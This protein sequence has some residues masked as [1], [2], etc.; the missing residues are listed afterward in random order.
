MSTPTI[1]IVS[2]HETAG[3]A[4]VA[5]RRIEAS[6]R[7]GMPDWRIARIAFFGDEN[8]HVGHRHILQPCESPLAMQ[9]MRLPRKLMPSRF[10]R[11]ASRAFAERSLKQALSEI[12]PDVIQL[13]N[14]HGAADW[15]WGPWMVETC[16]QFA[17]VVWTLHD[18]WSF[19]GRCAYAYDCERFV[20]GCDATCPTANEYPRLALE[21]IGPAWRERRTLY[22]RH[23]QR[24]TIVTPSRWLASQARRGLFA[25]HRID[26]IPYG[27]PAADQ[28]PR[29]EAR[30]ALGLAA[31]GPVL[32]LAAVDLRE[33]RKGAHILREL[34]SNKPHCPLT[35]LTMGSGVVPVADSPIRVHSLGYVADDRTKTLAYA[36]A[37][38]LLHPAPVENLPNTVLE[39]MASGTPTIALPIGGLPELVRQGVTGW[40]AERATSDGLS[41]AIDAALRAIEF[42]VD[43]RATCRAVAM[44]EYSLRLQGERYRTLIEGVSPLIRDAQRSESGTTS[45]SAARRG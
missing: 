45:R 24:L 8:E 43:M 33:R 21:Q 2:D 9:L 38:A 6:L 17:P 10:P 35:L 27:V 44:A 26:V 7:L 41:E 19:T 37:D 30:M 20:A 15:G 16:L 28:I 12:R 25:E 40:L 31:D 39:V 5:T 22:A 23:L 42:G 13:N 34:W 3:G 14:V 4:A 11:P 29:R 1:A 36:A 32:L 18:M